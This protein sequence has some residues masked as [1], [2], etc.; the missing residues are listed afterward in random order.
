MQRNSYSDCRDS[1]DE[2]ESRIRNALRVLNGLLSEAIQR[3]N[4]TGAVG[5]M[6]RVEGRRL[7]RVRKLTEFDE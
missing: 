3:G 2:N 6:V 7:G 5:V 1:S 4:Q